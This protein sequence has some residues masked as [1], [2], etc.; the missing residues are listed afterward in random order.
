MPVGGAGVVDGE[1]IAPA[2]QGL[3]DFG[4]QG[5]AAGDAGDA[6]AGGEGVG[7]RRNG[8]VGEDREAAVI[9]NVELAAGMRDQQAVAEEGEVVFPGAGG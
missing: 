5:Q 2:V 7:G 1:D 9:G 6:A 4:A 3:V 8:A